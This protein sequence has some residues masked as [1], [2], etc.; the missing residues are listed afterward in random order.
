MTL[1]LMSALAQLI[2]DNLYSGTGTLVE[3][4]DMLKE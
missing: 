1:L 2:G 4:R 3:H